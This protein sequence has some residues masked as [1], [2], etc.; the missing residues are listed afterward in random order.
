MHRSFP[1][2]GGAP[3]NNSHV[4][5]EAPGWN[6]SASAYASAEIFASAVDCGQELEHVSAHCV[7]AQVSY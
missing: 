7:I 2:T 5:S 6:F 4:P 1:A 3:R